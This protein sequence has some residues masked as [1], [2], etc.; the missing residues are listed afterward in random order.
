MKTNQR[1]IYSLIDDELDR[2]IAQHPDWPPDPI[3]AAAIVAEEAGELVQAALHI[4]YECN[5]LRAGRERMRKEAIQTAAMAV[6]FLEN[7][8]KEQQA[9][10][11]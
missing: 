8:E 2:A 5:D 4:V 3:H 10:L 6:R 11:R 9:I 7:L 1:P